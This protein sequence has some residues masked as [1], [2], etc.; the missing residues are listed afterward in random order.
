MYEQDLV[1]NNPQ[2]LINTI[3]QLN[4]KHN[5]Y[6][7][8]LII[9]HIVNNIISYYIERL[10]CQIEYSYNGYY[11]ECLSCQII[12]SFFPYFLSFFLLYTQVIWKD[13]SQSVLLHSQPT[14]TSD[15]TI[16]NWQTSKSADVYVNN[17]ITY[18]GNH[19]SIIKRFYWIKIGGSIFFCY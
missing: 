11:K 18:G 16:L 3:N 8:K 4:N 12:Y 17:L 14:N 15:S 9:P 1:L 13:L 7:V 2:G 10:L 5:V 6:Y 19:T